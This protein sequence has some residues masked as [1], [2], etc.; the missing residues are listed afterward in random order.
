MTLTV[1]VSSV[2]AVPGSGEAV[3]V[4]CRSACVCTVVSVVEL[5]LPGVGSLVVELTVAVFARS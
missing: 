1:K 3:L 2:P 4:T 5:L